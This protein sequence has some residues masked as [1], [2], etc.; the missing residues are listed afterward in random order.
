MNIK[1]SGQAI[2]DQVTMDRILDIYG[3]RS[4]HGFMCCP[5]H[6]E[7]E[8]SLKVYGGTN[9]WHCFGCGRG[10]S[11]IDFVMQQEGCSFRTAVIAIDRALGLGL[12]DPNENAME[13]RQET[14]VQN[15]LDDF[16]NAV[17][18]Y[19]DVLTEQIRQQQDADYKRMKAIEGKEVQDVTA[20]EW[21]VMLNWDNE[22]DYN[23]YRKEKIQEFRE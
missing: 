3:Y 16:V 23:E 5:F 22:D 18:A 6:G 4:R 2:R 13:A 1:A 19:C 20:D 9:G 7:K 10:G 21:T 17:Y 15:M 8:P 11:V 14:R 12:L